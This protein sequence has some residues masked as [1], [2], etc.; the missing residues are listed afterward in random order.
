MDHHMTPWGTS[1]LKP[2]S[3][4]RI[5]G[6]TRVHAPSSISIGS[7]TSVPN[8]QTTKHAICV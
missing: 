1:Y 2:S 5:L 8:R 6:P 4:T 7:L 3:N